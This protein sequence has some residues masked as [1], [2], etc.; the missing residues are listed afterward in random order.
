MFEYFPVCSVLLGTR[1]SLNK[2]NSTSIENLVLGCRKIISE[3]SSEG[4]LLQ[5]LG[6][7]LNKIPSNIEEKNLESFFESFKK[8]LNFT[9]ENDLH[10]LFEETVIEEYLKK[11]EEED[12]VVSGG[13]VPTTTTSGVAK[14]ELPL[15]NK[16]IKRKSECQE[17]LD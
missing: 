7:T 12:A 11:L 10:C 8:N 13:T 17:S 5:K 15:D 2:D 4:K 3:S 6:F 9:L 16:I 14:V 1:S